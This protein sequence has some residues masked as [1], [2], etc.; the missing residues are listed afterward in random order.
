VMGGASSEVR[1]QTRDLLIESAHFNPARV[2]ATARAA[3]LKTEASYR[4]ERGVDR[5]GI[6]R[7][8]DRAARLL[9]DLA[10]GEVAAGIVEARGNPA[11]AVTSIP[12]DPAH[13]NRLLGT[14]LDAAGV[15]DLL[16]RVDVQTEAGPGGALLC[17]PPGYRNDLA[18]PEDLIEEIARVFGYDQIPTT[19]PLAR[20][21]PVV[22][23]PRYRLAQRARD[24]LAGAGLNEISGFPA[25]FPKELDLLRF[26]ADAPQRALLGLLNPYTEAEGCLRTT[27][28]PLLLRAAQR[29][30]ARQVERVRLFEV[31]PVFLA[32]AAGDL[33][34]E[35]LHA[36]ALLADAGG[37]QLWESGQTVPIFYRA[38]GAV[39]RLLAD[40]G[41]TAS[42]TRGG[43]LPALHPAVSVDVR[44]DDLRLGS[45]GDL[46]PEVAAAFGI[47]VPCAVLELDLTPL[48]QREPE[49]RKVHAVSR[50]PLV[51]RDVAVL[52]ERGDAAAEVCEAIRKTGGDTLVDVHVFDRFDGK[53]IPEGKVS[54]AFRMVFQ[55]PDRT[56]RDEEVTK[57]VERVRKMLVH[58]FKGQLR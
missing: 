40:L 14:Q 20:L 13:P 21:A 31:G 10:G 52:L 12:L 27:L 7:A 24:A 19:S 53:G 36:G 42:F 18:I 29:N 30:L 39:E 23:P 8:A 51:R 1:E 22:L 9:A 46:H 38:R 28:L 58:R 16:A 47:E 3:G 34:D 49:P 57:A 41:V 54:L 37:K 26:A 44:V 45:V 4:F 43:R 55:H 50:F 6:A 25:T 2:R 17:R 11:P 15:R 5:E 33:P 32:R 48:L 56:L 35:R